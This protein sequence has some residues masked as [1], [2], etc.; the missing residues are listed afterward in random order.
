VAVVDA[1]ALIASRGKSVRSRAGDWNTLWMPLVC[2]S[3]KGGREEG[4]KG[5]RE[6]GRKGGR[7]E[8]GQQ[9]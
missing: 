1:N 8:G 4:R 5:G 2:V 7:E 6:E 3:R 9:Q